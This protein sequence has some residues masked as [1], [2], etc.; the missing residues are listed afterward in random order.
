MSVC[1]TKGSLVLQQATNSSLFSVV[2]R[3]PKNVS[4]PSQARQKL[5]PWL[6][7][8]KP[9]HW[10]YVPLISFPP[11]GE[12]ASWAF[13]PTHVK[14]CCLG[15]R[16]IMGEMQW[17]FFT[18][19]NAA[20]LSFVFVWVT[21]TSYL[22]SRVLIKAFWTKIVVKS[23]SLWGDEIWGFLFRHLADITPDT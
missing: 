10:A 2:S 5:V 13:S 11:K 20:L 8:Q 15:V 16:A 21:V 4:N 9:E 19:F 1:G 22:V 3:H 7:P 12:C 6:A 23:V 17:L 14:L 18:H